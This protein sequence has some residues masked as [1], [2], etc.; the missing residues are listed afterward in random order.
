[1]KSAPAVNTGTLSDTAHGLLYPLPISRTSR[2]LNHLAIFFPLLTQA[3]SLKRS[4]FV[5]TVAVL[6]LPPSVYLGKKIEEEP[7]A[8]PPLRPE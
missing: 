4:V 8:W 3:H 1:M 6:T 2:D 7:S 5:T